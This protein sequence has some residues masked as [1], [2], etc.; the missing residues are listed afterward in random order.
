[1]Q[2][3]PLEVAIGSDLMRAR[4][5]RRRLAADTLA[6]IRKQY[7]L[8]MGFMLPQVRVRDDKRLR[9]NRYEVRVFGM[10]VSRKASCSPTA[11]SR[12]IRAASGPAL[13]GVVTRDPAYGLP[14]V[15]IAEDRRAAA[16]S[17]AAT[18]W[19]TAARC[20]SL[21]SGSAAP[22]RAQPDHARGDRA[23]D[24]ARP[25][26]AG[27]ADRRAGAE[28]SCAR[29]RAAGAAEPACSERVSDP[30]HRVDSRSARRRRRAQQAT[31][32]TSPSTCASGSAPRSAS[33][34]RTRRARCTC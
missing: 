11:C 23:P 16:R 3:E 8:D 4:R 34:W 6:G 2:V 14:A 17:A 15:W 25:R 5:R 13:D 21:T 28:G 12:S 30:Q 33:S 22:E 32:S 1:M 20:S 18:R 24:R 10:R 7:A 19:S 31:R 26:A 27:D 29:R 9:P